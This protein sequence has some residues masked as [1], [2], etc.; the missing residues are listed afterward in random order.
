[1]HKFLSKLIKGI[2]LILVILLLYFTIN[3]KTKSEKTESSIKYVDKSYFEPLHR[4]LSEDVRPMKSMSSNAE[5]KELSNLEYYNDVDSKDKNDNNIWIT[6]TKVVDKSPL[7]YKFK[8]LVL[9]LHTV[10]SVPINLNIFVD[11]HSKSIASNY[12]SY[13]S[14]EKN[15]TVRYKFYDVTQS[16]GMITDIV[17]AMTP[18]FS[19]RP[20]KILC[21]FWKKCNVK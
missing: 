20:G 10:S 15:I 7:T 3:T 19:S 14:R 12:F 21:K 8:H 11:P 17:Q 5:L 6:L 2:A 13:L 4:F 16:A 9:N 1:M 18:Y